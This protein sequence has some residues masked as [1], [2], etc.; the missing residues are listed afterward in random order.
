MLHAS[1]VVGG[2]LGERLKYVFC[3]SEIN[4]FGYE[5]FLWSAISQSVTWWSTGW[6]TRNPSTMQNLRS[7]TTL[8]TFRGA[9]GADMCITEVHKACYLDAWE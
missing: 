5:M 7:A 6:R 1:R 2:L 3:N 8:S 4:I 9:N